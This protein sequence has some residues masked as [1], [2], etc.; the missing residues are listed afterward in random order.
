MITFLSPLELFDILAAVKQTGVA[1]P[2]ELLAARRAEFVQ[3]VREHDDLLES[4]LA[5]IDNALGE[6]DD[7]ETVNNLLEEKAEI[8]KQLEKEQ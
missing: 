4:R 3:Q 2:P 6:I 8:M 1:Y 7:R 5:A